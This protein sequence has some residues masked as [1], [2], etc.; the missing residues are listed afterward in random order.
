M[1]PDLAVSA[2]DLCNRTRLLMRLLMPPSPHPWLTACDLNPLSSSSVRHIYS[3]KPA[4]FA[5]Q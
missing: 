4:P 1:D 5:A 3:E 2:P